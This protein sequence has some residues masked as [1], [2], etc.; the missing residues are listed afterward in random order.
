MGLTSW[1]MIIYF[2]VLVLI[3]NRYKLYMSSFITHTSSEQVA[4]YFFKR[5]KE[6]WIDITNKKLQKLLYYTQAW[7]LALKEEQLF[8]E[9]FEAW[10]HWP[11]IRGVYGSYKKYWFN[12][13]TEVNEKIIKTIPED[14][15][16][17]LDN[18]W[19]VYGR[20]D[21]DYLELL[22]H[23]EKPWQEARNGLQSHESSSIVISPETMRDFYKAKLAEVKGA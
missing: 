1:L 13:I 4:N 17:F 18:I 3:Y 8:P 22:T 9:F 2:G 6:E 14:V 21:A 5:A 23:S 12:P 16:S 19:N 10:V 20:L 15:L 7:N 11:A